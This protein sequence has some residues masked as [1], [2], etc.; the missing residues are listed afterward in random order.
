[1][2]LVLVLVG[3]RKLSRLSENHHCGIWAHKYGAKYDVRIFVG[4]QN[5][6]KIRRSDFRRISKYGQ[7]TTFG[8]SSDIKIRTKYDVQIF[9]GYHDTIMAG[10]PGRARGRSSRTRRRSGRKQ[11]HGGR[12]VEKRH[13]PKSRTN[14]KNI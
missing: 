5:T 1:M 13:A 9:V 11:R 8:F 14:D 12:V 6:D 7:N 10:Q 3:V 4:Y 2:S